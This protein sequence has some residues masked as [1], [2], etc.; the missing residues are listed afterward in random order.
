MPPLSEELDSLPWEDI[1]TDI[2]IDIDIAPVLGGF[3]FFIL[4]SF[5]VLWEDILFTVGGFIIVVCAAKNL[6]LTFASR[7][8]SSLHLLIKWE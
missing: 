4:Q 6:P 7:R 1:D 8:M 2:A 5:T 3:R